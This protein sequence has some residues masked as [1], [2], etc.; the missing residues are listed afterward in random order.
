[1]VMTI[2]E[3]ISK[4]MFSSRSIYSELIPIRIFV[5]YWSSI[6]QSRKKLLKS[7]GQEVNKTCPASYQDLK[8]EIT[9]IS[10]QLLP[11]VDTTKDE[12]KA[13]ME[14]HSRKLRQELKSDITE[15]SDRVSLVEGQSARLAALETSFKNFQ[16][17]ATTVNDPKKTKF[18]F[19]PPFSSSVISAFQTGQSNDHAQSKGYATNTNPI[20][21]SNTFNVNLS[22]FIDNTQTLKSRQQPIVNHSSM[23]TQ[24]KFTDSVPDFNGQLTPLH[25]EAFLSEVNDYFEYQNLP[26]T[27]K[28]NIVRKRLTGDAKQWFNA[29]MPSPLT[30]FLSSPSCFR[31]IFGPT[32]RNRKDLQSFFGFCNFLN[33]SQLLNSLSHLLKKDTPGSF[34]DKEKVSLSIIKNA[35]SKH[36]ALTHPDFNRFFGI[37]TDASIIGLGAELFQVD[38]NQQRHTISFARTIP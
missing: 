4:D 32:L 19:G 8:Q 15:L 6:I 37:Q 27:F 21:N 16:L 3:L 7:V 22:P 11:I 24:E 14:R 38:E 31:N 13:H 5:L 12:C 26:D 17:F 36:V 33:H 10:I 1:M 20:L 2:G 23:L 25:P 9:L 28:I 29:L 35:F 30:L 18:S 34:K